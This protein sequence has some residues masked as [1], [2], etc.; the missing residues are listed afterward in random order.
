[1]AYTVADPNNPQ[2]PK[3]DPDAPVD[4]MDLVK[5]WL[6]AIESASDE[7]KTWRES[8]EEAVKAYR[9]EDASAA[10]FNIYH[11]NIET[12]V[13]ALYNSRPTPD[14]RR[15]YNDED[16]VGKAVS[17]ILERGIQ[18]SLDSYDFDT[19]MQAGVWDMAVVGRGLSRVRHIAHYMPD[20]TTVAFE[21]VQSEYVPWRSFRRGPGRL[22]AD[23]T[24]IAFELF[25]TRSDIEAHCQPDVVDDIP[26]TY[27]AGAKDASDN[28][29]G[30]PRFGKRAHVW[31]IW[32][33]DT[34]NVYF[35]CPDYGK[36]RLWTV[37]DPL[38]LE[39]FFP[40]PRPMQAAASTDT[41]VPITSYSI[42]K[43][44]ISELN[45]ITRRIK[46]LVRQLRP[47]GGYAGTS[48]DI[49]TI[50]EADDGELVPITGVEM[51]VAGGGGGIEKAIT[52]FPLE[53]V[54]AALAQLTAQRELIK[55]TIYEVT[56]I[57]DI[58]RGATNPNETLGAQQLK[59]QWGSLSVQKM[60]SEVQRFAR[61]LFRLKGE[62][63][64]RLPMRTLM[65]M[66][67][68]KYPSMQDKAMAQFRINAQEARSIQQPQP[69]LMGGPPAP[70]RGAPPNG[71]AGPPVSV[72]VI[73]PPGGGAAPP[74]GARLQ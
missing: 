33:R 19:V 34:R 66:T 18:Y 46:K 21:E 2:P 59:A 54:V 40:I 11:A 13:P 3:P 42:Y 58:M 36:A 48:P 50:T 56:K 41:L 63:L 30:A 72:N 44:L 49:K 43:N 38:E 15:R 60:Q 28:K 24:W 62:V 5:A 37:P 31:E 1:M 4:E 53:P 9:G 70:Q 57:A 73:A 67:G 8:G 7:E 55:Q 65:M 29:E 69:Q 27:S 16:P 51:F 45:E 64:C 20:G 39:G 61:D 68:L 32:D 35:I 52:W 14:I 17:D 6:Q 47:R 25:L 23:V 71:Q 12:L 26:F 22:W 10:D 74:P